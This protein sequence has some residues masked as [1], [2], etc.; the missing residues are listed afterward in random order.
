MGRAGCWGPAD[1]QREGK[2]QPCVWGGCRGQRAG[3]SVLPGAPG[4]RARDGGGDRPHHTRPH[5]T[6]WSL[7][8]RWGPGR[9]L[10]KTGTWAAS[11]PRG[12]PGR[13]QRPNRVAQGGSRVPREGAATRIR[14]GAGW[15]EPGGVRRDGET[16][17]SPQVPPWRRGRDHRG[18]REPVLGLSLKRPANALSRYNEL[19][20]PA[21]PTRITHTRGLTYSRCP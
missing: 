5:G 15:C 13:G 2:N 16:G 17:R 18:D 21:A 3:A 8:A 9:A 1:P 4:R 11:V 12:I 19:L 20:L 10:N 7:L 14:A 6:W